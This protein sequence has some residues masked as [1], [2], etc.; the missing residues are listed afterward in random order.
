[1]HMLRTRSADDGFSIVEIVIAT[2]LLAIVAIAILPALG[3]GIRLTSQQSAVAT[4]TRE[5]NSLVERARGNPTCGELASVA[6]PR[7]V[8]DGAGRTLRISGAVAS[9]AEGGAVRI[10]LTALD[11]SSSSLARVAAIVYVP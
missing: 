2:F 11:A 9:C 7:T 10:E 3:Q 5:L 4:A 8:A 6:A 1:M